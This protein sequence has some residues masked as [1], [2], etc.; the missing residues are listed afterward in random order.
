M[1]GINKKYNYQKWQ[2]E[3][4]LVLKT[5]QGHTLKLTKAQAMHIWATARREALAGK[6]AEHLMQGGI[7][8][9]G[10]IE[11]DTVKVK[12][13]KTGRKKNKLT[14]KVFKYKKEDGSAHRIHFDDVT[15]ISEYLTA[16]QKAFVDE[17]INYLSVDMAALGNE[18]S[19][20]LY[21]IKRFNEK[22]YIP[23]NSAKNF[24]YRKMGENGNAMLKSKSFTKET[25]FG[26]NNPL[27][28]GD[29]LEV[30]ASHI[31]EMSMYNAM[32]LPLDYFNRVWNYNDIAIE[33]DKT[34][35]RQ[36]VKSA[37]QT[38]YGSEYVTYVEQFLEDVNGGINTDA[39]EKAVD[40]LTS[41]FKKTAVLGSASV[42]IQ[43][44]SAVVRAFAEVDPR[45][46][47]QLPFKGRKEAWEKALK[48][49]STALLKDIGGFDT[50]SG[51]N[52]VDWL[53]KTEYKGKDKVLK[54][55]T[56]S[57]YRDDIL[58]WGPG[59]ADKVTWAYLW[60]ACE[61]EVKANN[62]GLSGE[63]LYE[64]TGKRFDEVVNK[65]QVYDSVI[66]RSAHMRSK[67]SMMKAV[68]AFMSEPT[69]QANMLASAAFDAKNG[70]GGKATRKVAAVVA[71]QLFNAMLVSLVYGARDDDEDKTLA[72]KYISEVVNNFLGSLNPLTLIPLYKDVVSLMQGFDVKRPDMNVISKFVDAVQKVFSKNDKLTVWDRTKGIIGTVG[73]M[74]GIPVTNLIRDAEAVVNVVKSAGGI[75]DTTGKGILY[76]IS[77]DFA[78]ELQKL[79]W[80]EPSSKDERMYN[81]FRD[82]DEKMYNRLAS[83]YKTGGAI[84]SALKGQIEEGYLEGK[85]TDEEAMSQFRRLG[86]SENEAYYEVRKLKEPV[87]EEE[88][89]DAN[90]AFKSFSEMQGIQSE[91]DVELEAERK[92]AKD[93]G[94]EFSEDADYT[95]LRDKLKAGDK[96]SIKEEISLLKEKGVSDSKIVG[97]IKKWL[98]ENDSDVKRQAEQSLKGNFSG[99]E[100]AV[101]RIADKYG[102]DESSVASAIRGAAG[103]TSDPVEGT[104]YALGDLHFAIES[105]SSDT[106]KSITDKLVDAKAQI[107]LDEGE[108]YD[109]AYDSARNAVRSSV[110]SKWKEPYQK[111]KTGAEMAQIRRQMW[112]TG[113]WKSSYELDD[114]L[115]GWREEK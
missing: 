19:M 3:K 21:G 62:K 56:D 96:D 73:D 5:V 93:E 98:K 42:V 59:F 67:S 10:E 61:K 72:E 57:Q 12:D 39:R 48:Y 37:M 81:A 6:D 80:Y 13:E 107:K 108:D 70:H 58:A 111:A 34:D 113:L 30:I 92:E 33:D 25:V 54:L 36:S 17:C 18:I 22:Y 51:Q 99:Y 78:P 47:V 66:T 94:K 24:I 100:S 68:T 1:D 105:G 115:K 46:F 8:F 40:K 41:R 45:Y 55:F 97:E 65:T 109:D 26:A 38:A 2:D 90:A 11:A 69:T 103:S 35:S 82:N 31:E 7:V 104:V 106:V 76:A 16:E 50:V 27:V 23:Y 84:K 88:S 15:K 75:K 4:E 89:E 83:Q 63:A 29:F 53:T 64:A 74:W 77:D 20:E 49:S 114:L 85:L 91:A 14:D 32:V 95:W 71:S 102:V 86:Y 79:N 44:P 60:N 43:Q 112:A 87:T 9:E 28:V 110:R 101:K 52:T